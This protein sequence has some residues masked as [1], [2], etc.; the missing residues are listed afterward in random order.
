M[1]LLST[2]FVPVAI[3][4]GYFGAKKKWDDV[5]GVFIKKLIGTASQGH[6]AVT[7]DGT[8]LGHDQ[9]AYD[10]DGFKRMLQAALDKFRPDDV[11]AVPAAPKDFKRGYDGAAPPEGVQVVYVTSKVLTCDDAPKGAGADREKRYNHLLLNSLGSDRLWIRKDEVKALADGKMPESL[12]ARLVR[13]HLVDTT[14]G[15]FPGAWDAKVL[16]QVEIVRKGN[17]VSGSVSLDVPGQRS[18]RAEL[19]GFIEAKGGQVT[20]F[21]LVVKG[22]YAMKD[23]SPLGRRAEPYPLLVV[24][25]LADDRQNDRALLPPFAWRHEDYLK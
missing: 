22:T 10:A 16:R 1:K 2:R 21:D 14:R 11:A 3:D 13:Y 20:R 12:T 24:F 9:S 19:L 17:Q 5:E 7:A 4:L 6:V 25:T 15:L 18:Y 8:V 23:R